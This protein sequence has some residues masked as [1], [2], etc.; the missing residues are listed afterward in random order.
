MTVPVGSTAELAARITRLSAQART[1]ANPRAMLLPVLDADPPAG[2]PTNVWG[3]DDGRIRWRG[4]NGVV[5][6][7]LPRWPILTLSSDPL[8]DS[9][10]DLYHHGPSDELRLRRSNGTWARYGSL[11]PASSAA[12]VDP[13]GATTVP[14]NSPPPPHLHRDTWAATW[15]RTLCTVHGPED[16]ATILGYGQ[17]GRLSGSH[18]TRRVMFGLDHA[19]IEAALAG[20][21]VEAVELT[22]LNTDMTSGGFHRFGGHDMADPPGVYTSVREQVFSGNWPTNGTGEPWRGGTGDITWFGRALRDAQIKG[23]TLDSSAHGDLSWPSFALRITY[24][25]T[26]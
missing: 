2:D 18:G 3:F 14:K 9:G 4:S 17:E 5:H 8:T 24:T 23:I 22:L 12:E 21:Q 11:A 26:H 7:I 13:G 16:G 1:G 10:I 6:E 15:G 19:A 25:H 20:S